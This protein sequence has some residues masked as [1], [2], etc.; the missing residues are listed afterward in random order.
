MRPL[1]EIEVSNGYFA[2]L[3]VKAGL[4]AAAIRFGPRLLSIACAVID[5]EL[6]KIERKVNHE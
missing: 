5:K 2:T 1:F 4:V 6:D 3:F